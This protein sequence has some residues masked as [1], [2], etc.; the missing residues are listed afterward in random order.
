MVRKIG[1]VPA[2][3]AKRAR[4]LGGVVVGRRARVVN[5]RIERGEV[6]LAA[7]LVRPAISH[8]V[9]H[10]AAHGARGVRDEAPAIGKAR[11]VALA[12]P[13]ER[14]VQQCGCAERSA[15]VETQLRTGE[16]V[17]LGVERGEK[18]FSSSG[19]RA[20]N[21]CDNGRRRIHERLLDVPA[22]LLVFRPAVPVPG[23]ERT[24]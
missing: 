16:P 8:I 18:I 19:R 20:L 4:M 9:D 5:R 17:Q 15:P 23:R 14:L 3:A 13:E 12:H 22:M 1:S 7:A 21:V 24:L 11:R 6:E 2:V 10:E